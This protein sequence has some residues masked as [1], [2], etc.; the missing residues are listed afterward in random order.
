M[1]SV[2]S[3]VARLT[4]DPELKEVGE[5]KTPKCRL[6]LAINDG[7]GDKVRT[8]F[9]NADVWGKPAPSAS[10]YLKKGSKVH[11]V[12]KLVQSSWEKDGIKHNAI[13]LNVNELDFLDPP[14]SKEVETEN[15]ETNTQDIPF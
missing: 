10:R 13:E 9:M 7:Y 12:G 5:N 8:V 6:G 2:V 14:P 4:R 3:V 1:S 15:T 11:I